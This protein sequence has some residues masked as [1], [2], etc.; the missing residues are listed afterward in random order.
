MC[1]VLILGCCRFYT[2][3]LPLLGNTPRLLA[4]GPQAAVSLLSNHICPEAFT[5]AAACACSGAPH[6]GDD[7]NTALGP[8]IS[9]VLHYAI[10]RWLDHAMSEHCVGR[11]LSADCIQTVAQCPKVVIVSCNSAWHLDLSLQLR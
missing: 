11:L 10:L 8:A 1:P 5:L 2:Q 9:H 6:W 3:L 4:A 7:T